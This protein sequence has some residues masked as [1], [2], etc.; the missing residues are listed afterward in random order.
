MVSIPTVSLNDGTAFPFTVTGPAGFSESRTILGS[1]TA[2]DIGIVPGSTYALAETVP[3][4]W[5]LTGASCTGG[6]RRS[7]AGPTPFAPA[8]SAALRSP[9]T[10]R[11]ATG[12]R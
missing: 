10:G 5:A 1:G 7:P 3:A 9:G 4:G 2:G 6:R 11:S 8:S 12:R